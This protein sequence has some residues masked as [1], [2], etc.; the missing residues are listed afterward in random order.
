LVKQI[1]A[2]WKGAKNSEWRFLG[3]RGTKQRGRRRAESFASA[4]RHISGVTPEMMEKGL[5]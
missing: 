2:P 5:P 4:D 1:E 3:R